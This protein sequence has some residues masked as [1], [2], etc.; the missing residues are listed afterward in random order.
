MPRFRLP[1]FRA[2]TLIEL[3]VVIAIIAVL[4]GLLLPAVQKVRE[5]AARIQCS[6]NLK[7]LGIATHACNDANLKLPTC[8]GPFPNPNPT[9]SNPGPPAPYGSV[10]YFLLPYME[11]ANLYNTQ[12]WQ[13]QISTTPI[14]SFLC[15]SD[16]SVPAN[17]VDTTW[18]LTLTSYAANESVFQAGTNYSRIPATFQDGTSNVVLFA[19]RYGECPSSWSGSTPVSTNWQNVGTVSPTFGYDIAPSAGTVAS[20]WSYGCCTTVPQIGIR[21]NQCNPNTTNS[22]HTGGMVTLLGDGSVRLVSQGVTITTWA[23]A[24]APQDGFILGPDW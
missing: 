12:Q 18:G 11:Q 16:P 19:E 22:G 8:G 15:P 21:V 9:W 6:N 1:R 17:G 10:H 23:Y 14:K 13:A 5:A 24:I 4:I 7:Q 3:L 2:F 20:S